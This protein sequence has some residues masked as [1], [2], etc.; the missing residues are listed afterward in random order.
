MT[1]FRADEP[2]PLPNSHSSAISAPAAL[3]NRKVISAAIG[4]FLPPQGDVLELA[5]GTGEHISLFA[6]R[7]CR[8]M[9]QPSEME[10]S[11]L[12][13][14]EAYV[15]AA[16]LPNLAEPLFLDVSKTDWHSLRAHVI[17]AINLLHVAPK[18]VSGA[19][20]FGAA[21]V[22]RPGGILILYGPFK[23]NGAF[24]AESNRDFDLYLRESHPEWGLRDIA[25]LDADAKAVGLG[26]E[27]LLDMP[28]NNHLAVYRRPD[29]TS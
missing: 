26:R 24:N 3:R 11:R 18:S 29:S 15:A 16:A 23:L 2:A 28:A 1:K 21:K 10:Q 22:L 7:Y 27:A 13:S 25:G 12:D 8:L 14:I 20:M 6:R 5:S 19:V 4:A 17:L 9:W